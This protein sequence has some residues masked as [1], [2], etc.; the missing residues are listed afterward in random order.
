MHLRSHLVRNKSQMWAV[1]FL[2]NSVMSYYI[3]TVLFFYHYSLFLFLC[4]RWIKGEFC[5]FCCHTH[6]SLRPQVLLLFHSVTHSHVF[7]RLSE[8][9]P[10]P[11]F[12]CLLWAWLLNSRIDSAATLVQIHLFKNTPRSFF[13]FPIY[14]ALISPNNGNSLKPISPPVNC[15]S[16]C[17]R[18]LNILLWLHL[19]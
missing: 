12:N 4:L 17:A 9:P 1:R 6:T 13:Y 18:L 3:G 7:T 10:L 16:I 14:F 2:V 8:L 11:H 19:L 15:K 5:L